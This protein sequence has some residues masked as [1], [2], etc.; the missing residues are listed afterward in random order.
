MGPGCSLQVKTVICGPEGSRV[1]LQPGS[2]VQ[3]KGCWATEF[4]EK[5]LFGQCV[6]STVLEKVPERK[7]VASWART[8]LRALCK[9]P[10]ILIQN[11]GGAREGSGFC[12]SHR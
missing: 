3:K 2:L 12:F 4:T 11:Q 9:E 1:L 7:G 6:Q 8:L 5:K 10:G